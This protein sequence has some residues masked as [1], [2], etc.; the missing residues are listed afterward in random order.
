[1]ENIIDPLNIDLIVRILAAI[2]LGFILGFERE[3][4]NKYAGLRTHIL[5]CLGACVFTIISIYGFPMFSGDIPEY[6]PNGIRDTARVAAQIVTGIGFIGAGTVMRHGTNVSGITTAATLWMC[7][8]I[9]MSCGCGEYMTAI[10][11]SLATLIVLIL[12]RRLEKNVLSKRKIFYTIYEIS[13]IEGPKCH[14]CLVATGIVWHI[15]IVRRRRGKPFPRRRLRRRICSIAGQRRVL[16]RFD[17]GNARPRI[18]AE[19]PSVGK[20]FLHRAVAASADY[21]LHRR[22]TFLC[23]S[24]R[25]DAKQQRGSVDNPRR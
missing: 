25:A 22:Q 3:I 1:M 17:S 2:G 24:R 10:I 16:H 8:A 4:T 19:R 14:A 7:A 13:I 18:L 21:R 9:G 11:A 23:R 6:H 12:I 15:H 20:G 5:V